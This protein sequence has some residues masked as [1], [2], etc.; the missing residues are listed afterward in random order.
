MLLTRGGRVSINMLS[1][2]NRSLSF[3]FWEERECVFTRK[4]STKCLNV[5]D[6]RLTLSGSG[7]EKGA[8]EVQNGFD[9]DFVCPQWTLA[10]AL[11]W[12]G[13]WGEGTLL[14]GLHIGWLLR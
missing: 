4:G 9:P 10:S 5:S 12:T 6:T 7:S 8:S 3:G 11:S 2:A 14:L 1:R 13:P